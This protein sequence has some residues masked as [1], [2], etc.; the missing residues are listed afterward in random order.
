MKKFNV[1][2]TSIFSLLLV[3]P[4]NAEQG[5]LVLNVVHESEASPTEVFLT[6]SQQPFEKFLTNTQY[7]VDIC[8][9]SFDEKGNSAV[10]VEP[11]EIWVGYKLTGNYNASGALSVTLELHELLDTISEQ[12][13]EGCAVQI[14]IIKKSKV[15]AH[16]SNENPIDQVLYKKGGVSY[17]LKSAD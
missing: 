17:A 13:T 9:T 10:S 1:F 5:I 6:R 4:A 14:P 12:T 8:T 16:F 11:G 2:V 7:F 15:M 3:M